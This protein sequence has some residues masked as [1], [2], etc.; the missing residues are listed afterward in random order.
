MANISTS[1]ESA[2]AAGST[3]PADLNG[4]VPSAGSLRALDAV[5]FFLAATLSPSAPTSP[6]TSPASTGPSRTWAFC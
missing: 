2:V 5:N 3:P 4:Q 1:A 6:P